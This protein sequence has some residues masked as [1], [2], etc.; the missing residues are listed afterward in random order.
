MIYP[1][2]VAGF[3]KARHSVSREQATLLADM[4]RG[5]AVLEVGSFMGGSTVV[6]ASVARYVVSVDPHDTSISNLRTFL[7]NLERYGVHRRV[8]PI[9]GYSQAVLPLLQSGAFDAAFIDG[10]HREPQPAWDLAQ[11]QRL[12]RPGGVIVMHDTQIPGVRA[13]L[14]SI[15]VEREAEFMAFVRVEERP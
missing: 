11:A 9:V 2:D 8:I 12:V 3:I 7:A 6:L 4:A 13:A 5:G 10:D 1:D 15:A 14:N